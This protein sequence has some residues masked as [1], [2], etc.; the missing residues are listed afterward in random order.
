MRIRHALVPAIAGVLLLPAAGAYAQTL[1]PR[2][3]G[4]PYGDEQLSNERTVTRV[5]YVNAQSRIRSAPRKTALTI[6]RLRY[7]TEDGPPE[8][9]LAL[10]SHRDSHGHV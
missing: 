7:R 2:G 3:T 5:G 8:V 6:G 4:G 10:Q 9:Y 1:R